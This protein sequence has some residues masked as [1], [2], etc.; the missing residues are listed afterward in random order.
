MFSSSF[1]Q[2]AESNIR[3][4][5]GTT[6]NFHKKNID[7]TGT[8]ETQPETPDSNFDIE[9]SSSDNKRSRGIYSLSPHDNFDTHYVFSPIGH[10]SINL[11]RD[12]DAETD[13]M[14]LQEGQGQGHLL[15]DLT[16]VAEKSSKR[17]MIEA[18]RA[19]A[20]SPDMKSCSDAFN[21]KKDFFVALRGVAM[22][23]VKKERELSVVDD[24]NANTPDD[25]V[26]VSGTSLDVSYTSE[27]LSHK[28][29]VQSDN[30]LSLDNNVQ[31]HTPFKLPDPLSHSSNP[32][33][34][35]IIQ[36]H[37][38][39]SHDSDSSDTSSPFDDQSF[40]S[41]YSTLPDSKEL[42]TPAAAGKGSTHRFEPDLA[43]DDKTDG[44]TD[45]LDN[46]WAAEKDYRQALQEFK[47]EIAKT[48]YN[49][50][51][52]K[53][54]IES[55]LVKDVGVSVNRVDESK[56]SDKT[57][58]LSPDKTSPLSA[59]N[60]H[61]TSERDDSIHGTVGKDSSM[62]YYEQSVAEDAPAVATTS[63]DR[64]LQ[65]LFPSGVSSQSKEDSAQELSESSLEDVP[66][67]LH[68]T[69]ENVSVD[70]ARDAINEAGKEPIC[71][72]AQLPSQEIKSSWA[73]TNYTVKSN[74][75]P[76]Q[77]KQTIPKSLDDSGFRNGSKEA[78]DDINASFASTDVNISSKPP[79]DSFSKRQKFIFKS[80]LPDVS[81]AKS[82]E[83]VSIA[84]SVASSAVTQK[85]SS[86]TAS[87]LV[88]SDFIPTHGS[89]PLRNTKPAKCTL[90]VEKS[91]IS[92][93]LLDKLILE[94]LC[95][96]R[97][98]A[99]NLRQS[100]KDAKSS[101]SPNLL[102]KAFFTSKEKDSEPSQLPLESS[103]THNNL[104]SSMSSSK[105]FT[106]DIPNAKDAVG[107][108]SSERMK[109]QKK[110]DPGFASSYLE[111][112]YP[113]HI[114]T[115][116]ILSDAMKLNLGPILTKEIL[117]SLLSAHNKENGCPTL[118]INHIN[119][120]PECDDHSDISSLGTG[121]IFSSAALSSFQ[122]WI[123]NQPQERID[124]IFN[125]T[126]R[127]DR[128]TSAF[129]KTE[130]S[131][132]SSSSKFDSIP[133]N[134]QDVAA[135]F[136]TDK[137]EKISFKLQ[138]PRGDTQ[139]SRRKGEMQKIDEKVH[140]PA[141]ESKV[142]NDF[143]KLQ[144]QLNSSNL[145][146]RAIDAANRKIE[147][148]SD[149]LQNEKLMNQFEQIE[150]LEC[151]RRWNAAQKQ[152]ITRTNDKLFHSPKVN[153]SVFSSNDW[154]VDNITSI[155]AEDTNEAF[156][157][158][159]RTTGKNDATDAIVEKKNLYNIK[160][161]Y[162]FGHFTSAEDETTEQN[163]KKKKKIFRKMMKLIKRKRI[164]KNDEE[165]SIGIASVA[166]MTISE[167]PGKKKNRF[168]F[169]PSLRR[170]NR[171]E[172]SVGDNNRTK[173]E[174]DGVIDEGVIIDTMQIIDGM[175]LCDLDD[176]ESFTTNS[177]DVSSCTSK[178]CSFAYTSL[179]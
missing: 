4:Q 98:G 21:T 139:K 130:E 15:G 132:L 2:N 131:I 176:D 123:R 154:F 34:D 54:G 107:I 59:L 103:K 48:S 165:R 80:E 37:Y 73:C 62:P 159:L 157:S 87:Y 151:Q 14:G 65:D 76:S 101:I 99:E 11:Q 56:D 141:V 13:V 5:Q 22:T 74:S 1:S 118:G 174:D 122:A 77:S 160:S 3:F 40:S 138:P 26:H 120:D 109:S 140:P 50:P 35:N 75:R 44:S 126:S 84:A 38:S 20:R 129:E 69:I 166:S 173:G 57:C 47:E 128:A 67:V 134:Q 135:A 121:S 142:L 55:I 81:P 53:Y 64:S 45:A 49:A 25:R 51:S 6:L 117:Q 12:Y 155:D 70:E 92:P 82:D 158:L 112:E 100:T 116:R 85:M 63:E 146:N 33:D 124:N 93:N 18:L 161:G 172:S 150:K 71:D 7:F 89:I 36:E 97:Q 114:Q 41:S 9:S 95:S 66:S 27:E 32:V 171:K 179:P 104:T 149:A 145:D 111:E 60:S 136:L 125:D 152:D 17:H 110:I 31:M 153:S 8:P 144:Q 119:I 105:Q 178:G 72:M 115:S 169:L 10:S 78:L 148:E 19:I 46:Y 143:D 102:D 58:P 167:G 68:V 168:K 16:P 91:N 24:D 94:D 163:M 133:V 83:T 88:S 113:D 23:P 162:E 156:S 147:R 79:S 42:L 177:S 30:S 164:Q 106:H 170:K 86:A 61:V 96:D 127:N 137:A 175:E 90:T 108:K 29:K 39:S 52:A 43:S 28:D